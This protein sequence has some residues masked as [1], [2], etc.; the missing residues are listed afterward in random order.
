MSKGKKPFIVETLQEEVKVFGTEFNVMAYRNE[1][2]VQTTLV[3]GSVGVNVKGKDKDDF[4]KI[5]PGEQFR[6]DK[7]SGKMEVKAVDVF[8]YVAWKDGL[9]VSQNDDLESIMRKVARWFDV[10]VFYQNPRLKEKRFFGIMK[11]QTCLDEVLEIIAK[12]GNVRFNVNGRTVI[13]TE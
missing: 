5:V 8:P 11:K 12:A 6:L 2:V 4:Q 10:E 13:V 7:E 1:N 9:F 3:S